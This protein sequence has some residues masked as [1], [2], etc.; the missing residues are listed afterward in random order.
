MANYP[1]ELL[2]LVQE[3][4]TDGVITA[5]ERQ[6]L[7]NKAT[8][9]GVDPDEFDLYIDAQVQKLQNAAADAAHQQK[10]RLCPFCQASLPMFAD[11]CPECGGNIT[12]EASKEVEELINTLE[13]AL[14]GFKAAAEN[15]KDAFNVNYNENA[16]KQ[17][18]DMKN[19]LTGKGFTPTQNSTN[20]DYA[21]K[22]AEVERYIRKA[23]MYYAN[24]KTVNYLVEEV[25][26]AIADSEKA[27]KSAKN[28]KIKI[29]GGIALALVLFIVILGV[30]L[31]SIESE[32]T[33]AVGAV[34]DLSEQLDTLIDE[35]D[36]K[37]ASREL[38]RL[39]LVNTEGTSHMVETY[40][41]VYLKVIRA[42]AEAGL[43]ND[44]ESLAL[45]YKSKIGND[46]SWVDSSCYT[47]LKSKYTEWN[48]DF[49][50][51]KSDYDWD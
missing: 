4:L 7:L 32:E 11:R 13:N 3:Y 14:V 26:K 37:Q 27:I 50:I 42:M 18:Y 34:T 44:A 39:V 49:S 16:M 8:A 35:G 9:L 29:I 43:Q 22:K 10:G 21:T 45:V 31:A 25:E 17:L 24:N 46:M 12:P 36:L 48:R 19:L 28:K 5:K 1:K 51:L 47:Y 20:Q 33:K 23:K 40:D 30:S 15:K 38:E 2:D 41:V 6:V